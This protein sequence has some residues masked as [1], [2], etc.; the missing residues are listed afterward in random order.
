[1]K[2]NNFETFID[3]YLSSL[4]DNTIV[5]AMKYSIDGGKRLRPRVI[6]NILK[7]FNIDEEY[8]YHSALALEMIHTYSLI[9][10]DLPAMDND[11]LRHGKPTLH[12]K[13]DE[14]I[15]ILAGDALLT[16][17]FSCITSSNYAD[18]IKVKM[19]DYLSNLSGLKG[20]IYGQYLDISIPS[21]KLNEE[22]LI[23]IEEG[24]TGGLFKIACLFA[25]LLI[26][27]D[28][29]EYYLK[30]GS[31]IGEF[32]QKL[33]DLYD[34]IKSEKEMGKSLSDKTNDRPSSLNLYKEDE[35]KNI[36]Y[37]RLDDIKNHLSNSK[38]E[39]KYLIEMFEELL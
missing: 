19:I 4:G 16:H 31:L 33:D 38:F 7:G 27:E 10:D 30:L 20:M 3:E 34:V 39:N 8:A 5:D 35:L 2:N 17:A 21:N 13:Y 12:I 28:N 24:K 15:A 32:Y 9:H 25:M 26:N 29:E 22:L 18:N 1:M 14:A 23:E 37:N 36:V 11:T 6:F